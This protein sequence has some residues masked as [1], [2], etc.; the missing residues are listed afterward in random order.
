MSTELIY[1]VTRY[2][3]KPPGAISLAH[4]SSRPAR[5]LLHARGS[6]I[7]SPS[8]EGRFLIEPYPLIES[9]ACIRSP[10]HR[11]TGTAIE[12]PI[13]LYR[14]ASDASRRRYGTKV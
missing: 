13:A 9:T 7:I 11:M 2:Y 10:V 1:T 12:L 3:V 14:A 6:I 8:N 5:R 4:F